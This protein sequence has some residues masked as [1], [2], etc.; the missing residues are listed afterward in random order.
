MPWQE[1]STMSLRKE[2]IE[3]V[4]CEG[5]NFS[6]QCRRFGISRN[7]GY[8]WLSRWHESGEDGLFDCSRRPHCSPSQVS[9]RLEGLILSLRDEHPSWGG[10]KLKRRLE[11]LGHKELPSPSTITE[12]LR[13]NNRLCKEESLKRQAWQ[14]F[15]HEEPNDLWQMDYKGHFAMTG[16]KRCHPLT[17][18][19]DHS[20]FSLCLLAC[21]NQQGITVQAALTHVF[22]HYGLPLRMTMDNGAPWGCDFKHTFTPLTVWLIRLG[23]RVGHSRPYHPQTQG[24]DERFHRTLGV[25][26]LKGRI[27]ADLDECQEGFD[28]WRDV[29][30]RQR[31]HEAI[32]MKTPA[33][34]YKP[35]KRS[36]PEKLL[37]IEYDQDD[38]VRKVNGNEISFKGKAYTLPK[39]FHGLPVALRNTEHDGK[40]DIYFMQHKI[41]TINL[42]K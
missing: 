27:F 18:L 5:S 1:V 25:E 32:G 30:N 29:Y 21:A 7:T 20:R 12:V 38:I 14:R 39:A 3:F 4:L 15:E 19:D 40:V 9:S 8:K 16:G 36:F 11:D 28:R 35:S 13:R 34:R 26:L 10:R 33:R 42:K 6:E 17:V 23:I 22:R 37:P 24:K 31:P 2:F 41:A